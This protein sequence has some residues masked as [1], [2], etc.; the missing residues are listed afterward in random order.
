MQ[1]L[2]GRI[3][4]LVLIVLGAGLVYYNWYQ[5]Q[6][7]GSYSMKMA[8]FGPLITIGGVFVLLFPA[9]AGKPSTTK[10]KII[11]LIVFLVGLA[12]GLANWFLMDPGFFGK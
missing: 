12:A 1:T 5:L 11:V 3:L 2:K 10:E 8:A 7:E 6:K 4:G 9:M